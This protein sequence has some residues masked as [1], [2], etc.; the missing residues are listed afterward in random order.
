MNCERSTF[1]SLLL[2]DEL[3][4]TITSCLFSLSKA[5]RV[6]DED[7]NDGRLHLCDNYEEDFDEM[8]VLFE[9]WDEGKELDK[10]LKDII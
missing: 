10:E 6:E 7:F 4:A 2:P 8:P 9:T 3:T 5:T 1:S